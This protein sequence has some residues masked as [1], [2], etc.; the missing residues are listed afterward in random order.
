MRE[1]NKVR[2]YKGLYYTYW[3]DGTGWWRL[4]SHPNQ[5]LSVRFEGRD[6]DDVIK[7]F[8]VQVDILELKEGSICV[9]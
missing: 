4:Q 2:S 6:P 5:G 9:R 1:V 3:E 7:K 8:E